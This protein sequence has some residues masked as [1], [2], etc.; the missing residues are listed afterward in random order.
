[1]GSIL[2]ITVMTVIVLL[3]ASVMVLL[4][5]MTRHERVQAAADTAAAAAVGA[6]LVG[7]ADPCAFSARGVEA[8]GLRQLRCTVI[9]DEVEVVVD[10]PA[11]SPLFSRPALARAGLVTE[12]APRAS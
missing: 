5:A 11:A 1:V 8:Q 2:A 10:E 9:G 4:V 12:D 7:V 6:A 3:G